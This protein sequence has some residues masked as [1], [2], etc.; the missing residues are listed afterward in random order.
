MGFIFYVTT[1]F[2]QNEYRPFYEIEFD[3]KTSLS[4]E[5]SVLA[6]LGWIRKP[7]REITEAE[8]DHQHHVDCEHEV[9]EEAELMFERHSPSL[10]EVLREIK[11]SA[12]TEYVT[13]KIE[14]PLD[15]EALDEKLAN[16][17][18]AHELIETAHKFY[19]GIDDELAKGVSSELRLD[20]F[21]T[22]NPEN[23]FITLTSLTKW[24]L[25]EYEIILFNSEVQ[26]TF[27][28]LGQSQQELIE[29]LSNGFGDTT[30]LQVTFALL[31]EAFSLTAN[32]FNKGTGGPNA[33]AIAT[34]I[35]S[36]IKDINDFIGLS[37]RNIKSYISSALAKIGYKTKSHPVSLKTLNLCLAF[38]VDA[39]ALRDD[40]FQ[41]KESTPNVQAIAE[42]LSRQ[43]TDLNEQNLAQIKSR[44]LEAKA[45]QKNP[46]PRKPQ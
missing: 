40:E 34:E 19:C 44:I 46:Y 20:K 42:H 30:H 17:K 11:D 39:F 22:I 26:V 10:F 31:V 23:I 36:Q 8:Y 14:D 2:M 25:K 18:K 7:Y 1:L 12:D 37:K 3:F 9:S 21:A 4:K 6:M 41:D 15:E 28:D 5:D 29:S 27:N 43:A 16:I 13:S 38:L 24:A 33:S 32:T 35:H 45:I